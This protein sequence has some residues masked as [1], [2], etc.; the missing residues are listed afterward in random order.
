MA[1]DTADIT[2]S[3][4]LEHDGPRF[5]RGEQCDLASLCRW[6]AMIELQHEHVCLATIDTGMLTEIFEQ[7]DAIPF[8]M[9]SNAQTLVLDVRRRVGQVMPTSIVRVALSA[10]RLESSSVDRLKCEVGRRLVLVTHHADRHGAPLDARRLNRS[11]DVLE[12]LF[13]HIRRTK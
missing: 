4:L 8:A 12:H 7:Q 6:I 5:S 11:R 13:Y 1:V 2:L 3:D 10:M 9:P